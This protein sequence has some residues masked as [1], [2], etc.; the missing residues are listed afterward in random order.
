VYTTVHIPLKYL[1][2]LKKL[3][4]DGGEDEYDAIPEAA[5]AVANSPKLKHLDFSNWIYFDAPWLQGLFANIPTNSLPL[6]LQHLSVRYIHL[7]MDANTIPHLCSL[8]SLEWVNMYVLCS[9]YSMT[10]PAIWPMLASEG[11]RLSR[12]KTTEMNDDLLDYLISFQ[13]MEDHHLEWVTGDDNEDSERL[14][15]IFF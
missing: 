1:K 4:V 14:A 2:N 3:L 10:S 5:A 8:T 12:L 11:I 6:K 7:S 15:R 13:G 9:E